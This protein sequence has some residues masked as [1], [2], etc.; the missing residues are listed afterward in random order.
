M[1]F[2]IELTALTSPPQSFH[3]ATTTAHYFQN[4]KAVKASQ[5]K[6]Q[7]LSVGYLCAEVHNPVVICV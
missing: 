7:I 2:K 4:L 6:F 3:H 1:A 5:I